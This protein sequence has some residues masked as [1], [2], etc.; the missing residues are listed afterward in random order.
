MN[1]IIEISTCK[2]SNYRDFTVHHINIYYRDF[3]VHHI[4]IYVCL[5]FVDMTVFEDEDEDVMIWENH[6][7]KN[8]PN[9]DPVRFYT[10]F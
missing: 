5:Q 7:Y 6:V 3:T 8:V 4:N 9:D 2:W 10:I 1:L